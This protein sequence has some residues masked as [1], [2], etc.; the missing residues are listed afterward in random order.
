MC[1]ILIHVYVIKNIHKVLPPLPL[2]IKHINP[3]PRGGGVLDLVNTSLVIITK[4][5]YSSCLEYCRYG[6]KLYPINQ[7][8]NQSINQ[9]ASE[10]SIRENIF[11]LYSPTQEVINFTILEEPS[12]VIITILITHYYTLFV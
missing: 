2:K 10:Q 11:C 6:I 5:I 3:L 8:I 9:S 4:Y 7:P 12:L 1:C